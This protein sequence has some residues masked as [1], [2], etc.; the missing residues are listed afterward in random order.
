M[1]SSSKREIKKEENID[2]KSEEDNSKQ[3][4]SSHKKYGQNNI[5]NKKNNIHYNNRT[6]DNTF[7]KKGK[8]LEKYLKEN[9]K[10][11]NISNNNDN[12]D[13][14]KTEE[15]DI[16]IKVN[17]RFHNATSFNIDEPLNENNSKKKDIIR[18]AES[19]DFSTLKTLKTLNSQEYKTKNKLLF[20]IKSTNR[21]NP[22][23]SFRY[24]TKKTNTNTNNSNSKELDAYSYSKLTNNQLSENSY[25]DII[26]DLRFSTKF[27]MDTYSSCR[28]SHFGNI[29]SSNEINLSKKLFNN[30][31][32]KNEEIPEIN[33]NKN[34][35]IYKLNKK[36]KND[37]DKNESIIEFYNEKGDK[38]NVKDE[39]DEKDLEKKNEI[40]QNI[41]NK[42]ENKNDISS[43]ES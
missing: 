8:N 20:S 27:N 7:Y 17:Q 19:P 31:N 11:N 4:Y 38:N 6:C 14:I 12:N 15:K 21:A 35:V 36:D 18:V 42:E 30:I 23:N 33:G 22:L 24:T 26:N 43:E 37:V 9:L 16:K 41:E 39:K 2:K 29:S 5:R 1:H 13:N 40:N 32:K 3:I 25:Q 28:V 10:D 34:K